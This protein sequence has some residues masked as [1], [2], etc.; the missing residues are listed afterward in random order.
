[1]GQ[2]GIGYVLLGMVIGYFCSLY[3]KEKGRNRFTWFFF[4]FFFSFLALVVL[5]AIKRKIQ[6]K[7]QK[8][9]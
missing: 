5:L 3:A 4:G 6:E 1:M 8:P 2:I 7:K 9:A